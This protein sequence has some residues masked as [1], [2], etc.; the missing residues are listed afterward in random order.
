MSNTNFGLWILILNSAQLLEVAV[1]IYIEV[2]VISMRSLGSRQISWIY[3][4]KNH[5]I[6]LCTWLVLNLIVNSSEY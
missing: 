4:V 5:T 3:R 2:A 6:V 1:Y